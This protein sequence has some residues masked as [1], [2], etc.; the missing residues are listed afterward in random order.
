MRMASIVPPSG[1]R[2]LRERTDG[3]DDEAKEHDLFQV[4]S[5]L[6]GIQDPYNAIA[7]IEVPEHGDVEASHHI[8]CPKLRMPDVYQGFLYLF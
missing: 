7:A 1:R 6:S 2:D 4:L 8:H 3:G 5:P